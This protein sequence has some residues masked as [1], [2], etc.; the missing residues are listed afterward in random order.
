MANLPDMVK[1]RENREATFKRSG[2]DSPGWLGTARVD[3]T[4][5]EPR[6]I[7]RVGSRPNAA[8]EEITGCGPV[9]V[10]EAHTSDEVG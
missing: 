4:V 6:E 8:R 10:G 2:F 5:E 9:G 1:P 7:R 3:R